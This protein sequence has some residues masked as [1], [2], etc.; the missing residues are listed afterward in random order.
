MSR[1]HVKRETDSFHQHRNI[2]L[3]AGGIPLRLEIAK[4]MLAAA[5]ATVIDDIELLERLSQVENYAYLYQR[6]EE[7]KTLEDDP[8][9]IRSLPVKRK[10][11]IIAHGFKSLGVD[12]WMYRMKDTLLKVEDLSVILV[13]WNSGMVDYLTAALDSINS[14]GQWIGEFAKI[15]KSKHTSY[16]YGV[17]FSLGA[18]VMGIAGRTS[19]VFDRIT[20]LDPAGYK[21]QL[22][23][24][25]ERS[26]SPDCAAKVDVIHTD[27]YI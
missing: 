10:V 6:N 17:G 11:V 3:F 4:K 18:H 12:E 20:G 5:A 21:F 27:G 23:E 15:C 25:S 22:P 8:N 2:S 1:V 13:G 7:R 24:H 16:S 14:V 19:G 26:L 9:S